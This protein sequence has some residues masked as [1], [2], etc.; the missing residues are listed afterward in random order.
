YTYGILLHRHFTSDFTPENDFNDIVLHLEQTIFF[1]GYYK[2]WSVGCGPCKKCKEC[3]ITA[4]CLHAAQARPSME[5]CGIDV[6]K[7][8]REHGLPIKT[9]RDHSEEI[10]TY[11]LILVE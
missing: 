6:F 7:T 2:A 9:L 1:D 3:N 10:D 5:A 8:A 11:G 4:T